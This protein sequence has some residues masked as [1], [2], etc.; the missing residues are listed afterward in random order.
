MVEGTRNVLAAARE[1]G[2]E[3][4]VLMSALGTTRDDEGARP[5]LRREMADGAGRA[6]VRA[7]ARDLPPEL[8]LREGRRRAADLRAAGAALAGRRR[9]RAR[10]R[11]PAADL[12][13]RR[14]GSFR[15]GARAAGG[16][17]PDVR[18]RRPGRRSWNELY[19][20]IA[21]VLGKRAP[22]VHVPF[23]VA[24]TGARL[25][26][27]IPMAPITRRPGDDARGERQRRHGRR[28]CGDVRPAAHAARRADPPCPPEPATQRRRSLLLQLFAS[29]QRMAALVDRELARD[30]V[31]SSGYAALSAIG[32]FGPLTLTELATMLGLPLTTAS[33]VVRRLEDRGHV[34]RRPHP[35]DGRAQLIELTPAGDA[36]W[37][38]GWPALQ[39]AT[40]RSRAAR[41][42]G[43]RAR[44]ARAARRGARCSPRRE[45]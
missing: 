14:R 28:R 20:R 42:R 38:A 10:E 18:A 24:R 5:V 23:A 2:V 27:S 1:A 12:D 25:V 29:Y 9:R 45:A 22:F 4:F 33:D 13:R 3:R 40:G 37:R 26:E 17:E 21:T 6:G 15:R 35:D 11:A 34:S 41:G 16:G 44:R 8:R 31:D 32:A 19:A 7:R 36:A 39:R 30:G 43:G